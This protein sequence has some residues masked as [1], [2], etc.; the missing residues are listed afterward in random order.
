MSGALIVVGFV[1][2]G[3]YGGLRC[4]FGSVGLQSFG[5]VQCKTWLVQLFCGVC[6][7][8]FGVVCG[9]PSEVHV[10][11]ASKSFVRNAHV[12]NGVEMGCRVYVEVHYIV[13]PKVLRTVGAV[14]RLVCYVVQKLGAACGSPSDTTRFK[15]G[16]VHMFLDT[17]GLFERSR[18]GAN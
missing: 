7:T 14:Q 2:F 12:C 3:V 11:S 10:G 16:R 8:E 17:L 9:S 1:P 6:I 13:H 4:C 15:Y 18:S 5:C